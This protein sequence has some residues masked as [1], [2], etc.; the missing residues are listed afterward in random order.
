MAKKRIEKIKCDKCRKMVNITEEI[1]LGNYDKIGEITYIY[2]PFC[3]QEI[4]TK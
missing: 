2:C 1:E 4:I 3:G